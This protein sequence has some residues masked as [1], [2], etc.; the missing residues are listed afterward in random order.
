M[1]RDTLSLRLKT[2]ADY[3]R[4]GDI[5]ADIGTDHGYLA[6][7]LLTAGISPKAV[8]GDVNEGPLKAAAENIQTYQLAEQ[9]EVLLGNGLDVLTE[10]K[11]DTV[12]IAGM[13][14]PLISSILES[15]K[16]QLKNVTRLIL[17]P[18]I[19]ADHIRVWL[20]ANGWKIIDE[21]IF[22]EDG[23]IYEVIAA[24]PGDPYEVY[25]VEIPVMKQHWLGPVLMQ[26]KNFA[27]RLKWERELE[28]LKQIQSQLNR[29]A[30][31]EKAAEKSEE[32]TRKMTWLKEVLN[33]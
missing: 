5:V 17:Q 25:S 9:A 2:V 23:H 19:A 15:G 16:S 21:T 1:E 12:I 33:E 24:E 30:N 10:R 32:V 11:A 26:T 22:A 13:G 7:Y 14:G 18:N 27:F 31:R 20:M 6:V 29:A 4:Q 3:V 8:L 28:Q